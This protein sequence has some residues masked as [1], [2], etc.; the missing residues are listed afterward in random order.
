MEAALRPQPQQRTTSADAAAVQQPNNSS[1][2]CLTWSKVN[3]TT[4][5]LPPP[6]SGA[7]S[8]VVNGC[9][10]VFGGYGG[11]TGRQNDLWQYTF[12]SMEWEK[13]QVLSTEQPGCRE[14]NGAVI[15]DSK[16]SIYLFGGYDGR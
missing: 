2:Q 8:V 12:A 14:N 7:A 4:G 5:N 11:G 6:R 9:L 15:S 1:R 10:Y 16:N 13:V 3:T